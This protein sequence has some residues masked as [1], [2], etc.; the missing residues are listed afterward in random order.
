MSARST[1]RHF[2]YK[3]FPD[4]Y[5]V[6]IEPLREC[7]DSLKEWTSGQSGEL[8]STAVG[9][10]EGEAHMLVHADRLWASTLMSRVSGQ[11]ES[12]A[13]ERRVTITTLDRLLE[14]RSWEPPI[15]AQDRYRRTSS[16]V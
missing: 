16:T 2:L 3:A 13:E 4:A 1:A 11:D 8:I 7:A 6:L 15:R 14:E 10:A 5:R 9:D 12:S